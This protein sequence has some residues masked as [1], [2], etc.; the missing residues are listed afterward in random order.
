MQSKY[1]KNERVRVRPRMVQVPP[2]DIPGILFY[3]L[4]TRK[5]KDVHLMYVREKNGELK[6]L[7]VNALALRSYYANRRKKR[8]P[9]TYEMRWEIAAKQVSNVPYVFCMT[10][11]L[12]SSSMTTY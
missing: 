5:E 9:I 7:F 3:R 2:A 12:V 8:K 6:N 1:F 11:T 4:R 10:I